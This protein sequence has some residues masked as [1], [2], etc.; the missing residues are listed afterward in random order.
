MNITTNSHQ[1]KVEL[2]NTL[3]N[4]P[5][6]VVITTEDGTQRR[7]HVGYRSAPNPITVWL[8]SL[9]DDTARLAIDSINSVHVLDADDAPLV[10]AAITGDSRGLARLHHAAAEREALR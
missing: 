3:A 8:I 1:A 6:E 7:G 9:G 4:M 10:T 2:L 5:N